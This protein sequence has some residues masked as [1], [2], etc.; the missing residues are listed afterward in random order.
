MQV[1]GARAW[2]HRITQSNMISVVPFKFYNIQLINI[3]FCSKRLGSKFI[4]STHLSKNTQLILI[5]E[6]SHLQPREETSTTKFHEGQRRR[7]L[8]FDCQYASRD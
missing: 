3:C 6:G 5:G 2:E 4:W 1:G 8:A 7:I